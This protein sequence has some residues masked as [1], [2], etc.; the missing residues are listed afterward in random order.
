MAWVALLGFLSACNFHVYRMSVP[1]ALEADAQR[2]DVRGWLGPFSHELR[3][4]PYV[5]EHARLSFQTTSR[6]GRTMING[7]SEVTKDRRSGRF[8]MQTTS[9]GRIDASCR[10]DRRT[11]MM[12]VQEFK[13]IGLRTEKKVEM[14]E[15]SETYRCRF[16]RET[17]SSF[18]LVVELGQEGRVTVDG[19]DIAVR[20]VGNRGS[21][22][23]PTVDTREG[24]LLAEGDQ[25]I[26][27]VD[28]N[29]PSS[30]TLKNDL[31]PQRRD[32]VAAIA[33]GLLMLGKMP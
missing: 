7:A 32:E 4:G 25:H 6:S 16:E 31:A 23:F 27:A 18:E 10:M 17:A 21:Q 11:T 20:M 12:D 28:F 15:Q 5:A 22:P 1:P 14:A 2:F 8:Q 26:A 29:S 30:V 19:T 3:V 33:I 13:L 9:V 24:F